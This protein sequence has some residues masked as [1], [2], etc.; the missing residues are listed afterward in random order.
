MV[1]RHEIGTQ[2]QKSYGTGAFSYCEIFFKLIVCSSSFTNLATKNPT[3]GPQISVPRLA[4][5][6]TDGVHSI[7][8]SYEVQQRE[9]L[10]V[11]PRSLA[12]ILVQS[13]VVRRRGSMGKPDMQ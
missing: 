13:V 9:V 2:T 10:E 12:D 11:R 6:L 5:L 7:P 4:A 1:S 8:R 3:E